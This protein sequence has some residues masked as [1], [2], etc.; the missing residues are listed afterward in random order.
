MDSDDVVQETFLKVIQKLDGF[1][2]EH[3]EA[4]GAYL[5]VSVVN[6]LKDEYKRRRPEVTS[7]D[8]ADSLASR[9]ATPLEEVMGR[10]MF[11]RYEAALGRL[12]PLEREMLVAKLELDLDYGQIA[13]LF[14]K[15]TPDAARVAIRRALT[16]LGKEMSVKK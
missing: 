11:E 1:K 9:L 7:L 13:R 5:R 10:E 8:G 4:L 14:G 15:N 2:P 16:R 6:R 12:K 3:G